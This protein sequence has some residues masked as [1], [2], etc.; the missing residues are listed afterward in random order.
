MTGGP[1]RLEEREFEP[2]AFP[3]PIVVLTGPEREW[4]TAME[5]WNRARNFRRRVERIVRRR[6]ISFARWQ[7]L[8]AT[9]RLI[10]ETGDAVSQRQVMRRTRHSESSVSEQMRSLS[11][12]GLVD[13]GPDAWGVSY[14]I[15]MTA[16][17]ERLIARLRAELAVVVHAFTRLPERRDDACVDG[18]QGELLDLAASE[19]RRRAALVSGERARDDVE[20]DAEA[21]D[22]V[23]RLA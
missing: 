22:G 19:E 17:G 6:G 18:G 14:R 20:R 21:R 7:V 4:D 2:L 3:L 15:W 8:E 5:C 13:V 16:K 11:L 10:R 9:Q 1:K 23:A 12:S